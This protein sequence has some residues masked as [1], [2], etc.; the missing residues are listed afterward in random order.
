ML[1][2]EPLPPP[3]GSSTGDGGTCSCSPL[4]PPHSLASCGSRLL[5]LLP[6]DLA[7]TMESCSLV[8]PYASS[9]LL[10]GTGPKAS[11]PSPSRSDANNSGT[12]PQPSPTSP[13]PSSAAVPRP[14]V[15]RA[16]VQ[17]LAS[18]GGDNTCLQ[19]YYRLGGDI[20]HTSSEGSNIVGRST[21]EKCSR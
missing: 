15:P 5:Y 21:V 11:L 3:S 1:H 9:S 14:P 19:T 18:F 12:I 2:E 13:L 6:L 17:A 8:P 7:S 4:P 20:G 10:D 16:Y